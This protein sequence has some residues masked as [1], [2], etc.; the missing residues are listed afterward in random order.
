MIELVAITTAG[1]STVETA[2]GKTRE[3]IGDRV[4]A[5]DV[6]WGMGGFVFN[7]AKPAGGAP[8]VWAEEEVKGI[9]FLS[10]TSLVLRSFDST[11]TKSVVRNSPVEGYTAWFCV[12]KDTDYFI[13]WVGPQKQSD[14][15]APAVMEHNE[16]YEYFTFDQRYAQSTEVDA[17]IDNGAVIWAVPQI[18]FYASK[19]EITNYVAFDS[20]S[21]DYYQNV[22]KTNT[23]SVLEKLQT[24]VAPFLN[25][26]VDGS[27]ILRLNIV[28]Q[29]AVW[30]ITD[31]QVSD[32]INNSASPYDFSW[33][34]STFDITNPELYNG[35]S[36]PQVRTQNRV[37]TV[38]L[39]GYDLWK[40]E[41]YAKISY[42]NRL[43]AKR[44]R[45]NNLTGETITDL[46]ELLG[47]YSLITLLRAGPKDA[48]DIL[49][50]KE[51][52]IRN[53]NLDSPAFLS[54][55]GA[56]SQ[57]AKTIGSDMHEIWTDA[58]HSIAFSS[59]VNPEIS[60]PAWTRDFPVG[61]ATVKE[62][63]SLAL[64]AINKSYTVTIG[65]KSFEVGSS[66]TSPI[67]GSDNKGR[68]WAIGASG[69]YELYDSKTKKTKTGTILASLNRVA[70]PYTGALPAAPE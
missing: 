6:M 66:L 14:G 17:Y 15:S 19:R 30:T 37:L 70:Y 11:K 40:A 47:T 65:G 42:A 54:Q 13:L 33:E 28:E 53:P 7:P 61:P 43:L 69:A 44:K 67:F 59:G 22:V 38:E 52:W 29:A 62:S 10:G 46:Y 48:A 12:E 25:D 51:S 9:L 8:I 41:A 60:V 56:I 45:T 55:W 50:E 2:D 27:I 23:I 5:G 34:W 39:E 26:A 35:F 16:E 32:T 3:V 31:T 36:Y 18:S 24:E 21:F 57:I 49:Y 68:A 1:S 58:K 63:R 64:G 20:A 4:V